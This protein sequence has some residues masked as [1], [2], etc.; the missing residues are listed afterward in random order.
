MS[1]PGHDNEGPVN[2]VV[3]VTVPVDDSN[4]EWIPDQVYQL[5]VFQFDWKYH[6]LGL[7]YFVAATCFSQIKSSSLKV[8]NICHKKIVTMCCILDEQKRLNPFGP[9][10]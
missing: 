2:T 3:Q 1:T 7:S 4:M 6:N 8:V 10:K 9:R 5:A